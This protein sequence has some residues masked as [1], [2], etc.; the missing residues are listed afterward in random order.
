MTKVFE[1]SIY[2]FTR[3]LR[4]EDNTSLLEALKTSNEVIPIFIFNPVQVTSNS[5]KSNNSIQFMCESLDELNDSL[6]EKK[7]KLYYFYGDPIE[8][9]EKLINHDKDIQ[10][11]FMNIDYTPFAKK[12]SS[13]ISKLCSKHKIEFKE[14]ED[15]MLTG[16]NKVLKSDGNPYVKFTPYHRAAKKVSIPPVHKN[17]YKNYIP[18]KYS[19]PNEYKKNIHDFYE[20]NPDILVKGG[21]SHALKILNN[22]KEFNEYNDTRDFP[23]HETTHLSAYLKF[24][25]VSIREVYTSFKS[26]LKT[27]NKLLTQL[28][29]R[30]FYMN[31]CNWFPHVIGA[32][33]KENYNI[34]WINDKKLFNK[35]KEGKTGVP[36]VDAGMRQ[37][38]S[39]GY[40]HNRLRMIVSNFLIKILHIDWQWGEKYFA[41][42]LVDYCPF[43]N[44]GGWQ[45]SSSTG[46]DSQPYFR[47]FNPWLQAEKFDKNCEFIKKWVPE[48]KDVPNKDIL[49]W[50]INHDKYKNIK[51]P[52]PI[53]LD[54][55]AAVKKTQELYSS[56]K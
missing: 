37:M 13:N 9:L 2:I 20:K 8:I 40:M 29:W 23:N 44:N 34:K 11:V 55:K 15:Y 22:L 56:R 27:T 32:P 3:D 30:D 5:Y 24:N 42:S 17:N 10:G 52:A 43:N 14:F 25:C 46:S 33:M 7:S 51:Y 12:R 53:V 18:S 41:Q 19:P 35:W 50:N 6:H 31:I 26:K 4:L 36:I 47:I 49:K 48:L 1:K 21:R 39:C 16:V 28:Y 38:N 54:M 45:W